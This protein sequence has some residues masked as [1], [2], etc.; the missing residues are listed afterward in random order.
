MAF[1]EGNRKVEGGA[2]NRPS[3]GADILLIDMSS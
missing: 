3:G 1:F 2:L